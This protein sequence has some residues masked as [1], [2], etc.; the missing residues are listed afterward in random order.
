MPRGLVSAREVLA[1]SIIGFGLLL[2]AAWQ[3][4]P[5]CLKLAPLAVLLLVLRSEE[6]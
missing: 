3:L 5:L 1:L 4:N 2:L 6:R